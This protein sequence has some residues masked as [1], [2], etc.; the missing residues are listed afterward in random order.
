MGQTLKE[1]DLKKFEAFELWMY[2]IMLRV[3]RKE[4][5]TNKELMNSMRRK[6]K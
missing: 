5:I 3:S 6:K 2:C 4:E 1:N